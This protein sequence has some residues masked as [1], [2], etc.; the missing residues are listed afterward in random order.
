MAFI[1]CLVLLLASFQDSLNLSLC[2]FSLVYVGIASA[3]GPEGVEL[4]ELGDMEKWKKD[5]LHRDNRGQRCS[6]ASLRE[7]TVA[8]N[9]GMIGP[10]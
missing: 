4:W 5:L 1:L 9:R 8:N 7:G 10:N 6:L 3:R 2:L